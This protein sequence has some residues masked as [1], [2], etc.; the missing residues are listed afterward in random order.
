MT[1]KRTCLRKLAVLLLLILA[2]PAVFAQGLAMDR[3]E[4]DAELARLMEVA[5]RESLARVIVGF[6]V[7]GY[8]NLRA[9]S[10]A[11]RTPD[12]ARKA[13]DALAEAIA[14]RIDAELAAINGTTFTVLRRFQTVPFV[15]LAAGSD[16]LSAIWQSPDL[17]YV[18]ESTPIRPALNTTIP[19]IGADVTAAS[20]ATGAGAYVAVLDSGVLAS[21]EMF[22]GKDIIQACFASGYDL[23]QFIG[24]CPNGLDEDLLSENPAQ[25]YPFFFDGYDHG[26]HV[27]GIAV[28]NSPNA[29]L[30]GVARG[31]DLI[32]V[33]VFSK[34]DNFLI[35]GEETPTC[36]RVWPEDLLKG[37]EYVY[38]LRNEVKI[39]SVNMSLGAGGWAEPLGCDLSVL[40]WTLAIEALR[41]AGIAPVASAGN[42]SSCAQIGAPG[43]I[44][45]AI[46]VGATD[47]NDNEAPFSDFN[48][49]I[50]DLYAPGVSVNSAIALGDASYG[51][52]QGTSMA[53]PHVAGAFAV[54]EQAVPVATMETI[55]DALNITGQPVNGRCIPNPTQ[56]RIQID[57]A[58]QYLTDTV[59]TWVDFSYGGIEV[60][61]FIQPFNT[62]SEGVAAT[63]PNGNMTI[64]AGSTVEQVLISKSMTIT[65]DGG[66]AVITAPGL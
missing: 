54:L 18:R 1:S 33:N 22:A 65:A 12:E 34:V 8:E 25:P 41:D 57:A 62:V 5:D 15:A 44:S 4:I 56:P 49:L 42:E 27:A 28:G 7:P 59:T 40:P 55:L 58:L 19:L 39:A 43:C 16:A 45:A 61:T 50:L 37:L 10:I 20:G 2:A 32:A 36:V 52:K 17:I 48:P 30:F 64:K 46:T 3:Y 51:F 23:L 35:C 60:G 9:V 66:S 63:P 14:G 38:G 53:A 26:T 6:Q 11:A 31:A 21:H 29:N 47:D 24:T 13:D